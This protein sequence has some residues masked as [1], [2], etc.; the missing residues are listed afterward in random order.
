MKDIVV[1]V[2]S[3]RDAAAD[4]P[5]LSL[6][7]LLCPMPRAVWA[8]LSDITRGSFGRR[9][10]VRCESERLG[11]TLGVGQLEG[12]EALPARALVEAG[13][14]KIPPQWSRDRSG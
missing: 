2:Q 5:C 11:S 4:H 3:S 12:L 6:D 1:D 14:A 7:L 8:R 9:S 13:E 10:V